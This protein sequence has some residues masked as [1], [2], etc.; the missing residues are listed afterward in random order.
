MALNRGKDW[1][2]VFKECFKHTF[3]N[4]LVCRIP[5]QVSLYKDSSKNL[6]DFHCFTGNHMLMIECKTTKKENTFNFKEIPQIGR[7]IEYNKKENVNEPNLIQGII[8][9]FEAKKKVLW[10]PLE[11]CVRM[12][13]DGKKSI[14]ATKSI[15]EGY[16]LIEVPITIKRVFP[17]CDCSVLLYN[18]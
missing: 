5:D 11:E 8:I 1:E 3:P 12:I 10:C 7:M 15:A 13:N 2:D 9:W 4:S 14:N 17:E 18:K 16:H 6:C